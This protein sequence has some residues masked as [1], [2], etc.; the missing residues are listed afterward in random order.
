MP[1]NQTP[2]LPVESGTT[3]PTMICE[4]LDFVVPSNTS[5]RRLRT[6]RPAS[7]SVLCCFA[8]AESVRV[9]DMLQGMVF[10]LLFF[11]FFFFFFLLPGGR[12]TDRQKHRQIDRH[13]TDRNTDR[14]TETHRQTDRQRQK[15]RQTETD[16]QAGR[17]ADRQ[18]VSQREMFLFVF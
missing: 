8:M 7:S 13:E 10:L 4:W 16:R 18:T 5:A 14:Q 11:F 1:S 12:E 6:L 17:Q 9:L 2:L 15:H 3:S